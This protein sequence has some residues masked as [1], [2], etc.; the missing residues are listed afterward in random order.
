MTET[1]RA[2]AD[3]A[4][5]S[6][7]RLPRFEGARAVAAFLV[8]L[9]HAGFSS[10]AINAGIPGRFLARGDWGVALFFG[11]S[12]FLLTRAWVRWIQHDG[13]QPS[14]KRYA[15]HRTVRIL[16]AYYVVLLVILLTVGSGADRRTVVSNVLLI[17]N[18]TGT[19]LPEFFLT[20]SLVTEVAFYAILPLLALVVI[21]RS[22]PVSLA[23]IAGVGATAYVY[24]FL[25]GG[26]LAGQVPMFAGVWLPARLDWFCVGMAVAVLEGRLRST[27]PMWPA[28]T[29][30]PSLLLA[31]AVVVYGV[32]MTPLAGPLSIA[33]QATLATTLTKEFLY[34]LMALLVLVALLAPAAGGTW[35]GRGLDSPAM[36]WAG[37]LSYAFFLWHSLVLHY[38]R[39][40][41]DLPDGGGGF[42]VSLLGTTVVT[43]VICQV[44]WWLVE[45]P[46]LKWAGAS[47]A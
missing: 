3:A 8:L 5:G 14:L 4:M 10:D 28:V 15:I 17:Q 41:L 37:R 23:L 45:R 30:R 22:V 21:R 44:S 47:T 26:P 16:P 27:Q 7:G 24:L 9:T 11:L 13:R 32:A 20:W 25:I 29:T 36:R 12:G 2:P 38:V 31:A 46:P 34:G 6:G 1:V 39:Q 35:W 42:L 40:F 43:L 19:F 33:G 18:Y